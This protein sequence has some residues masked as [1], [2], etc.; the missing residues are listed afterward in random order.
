MLSHQKI[1]DTDFNMC[2][3]DECSKLVEEILQKEPKLEKLLLK[4]SGGRIDIRCRKCDENGPE[5][6]HARAFLQTGPVEVV[7]CSNRLKASAL[8]EVIVHEGTH[9]YDFSNGRCDFDTCMGLAYSEVRAARDAE[10]AGFYPFEWLR[11][12]CIRN[13]ATK[14]TACLVPNYSEA[15]KCVDAVFDTAIKDLSPVPI[16]LI[17]TDNAIIEKK[18]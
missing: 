8:R 7:L 16:P 17:K 12:N 14:S 13:H 9:A 1:I 3:V 10:C 11:E 5:G 18:H 15:S 2:S 4:P 6:K